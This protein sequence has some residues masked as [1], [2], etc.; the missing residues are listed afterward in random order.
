MKKLIVYLIVFVNMFMFN[1]CKFKVDNNNTDNNIDTDSV[2]FTEEYIDIP[3]VTGK[4]DTIPKGIGD[5][6]PDKDTTTVDEEY[7][8]STSIVYPNSDFVIDTIIFLKKEYVTFIVVP[9]KYNIELFNEKDEASVHTFNTISKLKKDNKEELLF[10]MNAGMYNKKLKPEG[11]FISNGIKVNPINLKTDGVGNFYDLPPN[12]VF[13]IDDTEKPFLIKSESFENIEAKN[14]IMLATQSG[15]MLVVNSVFNKKFTEGSKNLNIRNGVGIDDKGRMV[16]VISIDK[17]NFYEFS[18]L[19]RDK[20]KCDNALYLDGV[21]SKY[22]IPGKHEPKVEIPLG[23]I[24]T[25]SKKKK[26]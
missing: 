16:F 21:V 22:F 13:A 6:I 8:D 2:S 24:I 20:L 14:K 4:K 15:P 12:G 5:T 19:F 25:V 18:E 7:S 10:A 9:K 11:L 3:G 17:V 1:A 23:P 26:L